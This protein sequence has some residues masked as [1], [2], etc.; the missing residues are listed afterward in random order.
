[1]EWI[2][3]YDT[4]NSIVGADGAVKTVPIVMDMW[5][6]TYH[7]LSREA[8]LDWDGNEEQDAT[9]YM[10][11][12]HGNIVDQ[13]D[14]YRGAFYTISGLYVNPLTMLA[15]VREN[16]H[17]LHAPRLEVNGGKDGY[18]LYYDFGGAVWEMSG[19]FHYRIYSPSF[20]AR[21]REKALDRPICPQQDYRL[22]APVLSPCPS[23]GGIH[24]QVRGA[25]GMARWSVIC[26]C[27]HKGPLRQNDDLAAFAWNDGLTE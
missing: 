14:I 6:K 2:F 15:N 11:K 10:N 23:C 18:G 17:T 20:A 9:A 12:E 27:G 24:C 3:R 8:S 4:Q 19:R 13:L 1:M 22:L 16:R 5:D 25:M 21:V 7:V 26:K